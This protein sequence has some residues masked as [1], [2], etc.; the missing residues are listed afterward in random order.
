MDAA[1]IVSA[2]VT[3][4]KPCHALAVATTAAAL[5]NV[6]HQEAAAAYDRPWLP[7]PG[8]LLDAAGLTTYEHPSHATCH[9]H[10]PDCLRRV[11]CP[12]CA[13]RAAMTHVTAG[14]GVLPALHQVLTPDAVEA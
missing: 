10:S 7:A 9:M 2:S 3:Q 1:V 4:V 11:M 12:G 5:A 14:R 13:R 6:A 8:R